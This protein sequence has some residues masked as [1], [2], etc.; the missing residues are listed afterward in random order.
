MPTVQETFDAMAD[1]FRADKAA[2]TNATI[3]Y[4]VSGDGAGRGTR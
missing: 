2:G 3:Q 1:R 4:D